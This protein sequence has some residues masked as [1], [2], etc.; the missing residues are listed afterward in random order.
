MLEVEADTLFPLQGALGYEATQSLF[1]GEHTLLVE[2]PSDILYLHAL[3]RALDTRGRTGLDS[4]WT[5]CPAGGIDRIM[6]F[7]SLFA[8]KDL[9]IAVLADQAQGAKGKVNRISQMS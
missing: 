7:V 6:P 2:G 4:R 3:S 5:M 1:V 8:G 9:H